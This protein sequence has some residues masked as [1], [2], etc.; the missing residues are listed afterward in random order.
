MDSK[1]DAFG[2]KTLSLILFL[3]AVAG[4]IAYY[5]QGVTPRSVFRPSGLAADYFSM[6]VG[7]EDV[8]RGLIST[9]VFFL[10]INLN[11][12]LVM[13]LVFLV[14]KNLIK[15]VLDRRRNILG[16]RLRSRLVS[17]FVGLSLIPT[18]LLFFVAKGILERV[19]GGWFSPQVEA[20]VEG[21]LGVARYHYDAAEAGVYRYTRHL[22]REI[23]ELY[24]YLGNAP[25]DSLAGDAQAMYSVIETYLSA[26]RQEYGLL[27]LA[28]LNEF[29]VTLAAASGIEQRHRLVEAP[30]ANLAAVN[31]A[32]SGVIL[33]RT[34][35]SINA[36]F[37]RGYAPVNASVFSG[38]VSGSAMQRDRSSPSSGAAASFTPA[39]YVI[40]ATYWVPPE[41]SKTLATVI[42]AHEDYIELKSYRR[43]L[44]SSYFLT[45]VV[46]TLLIVFGAIWVGF[47]LAKQLSIP[48]GLIAEGTQQVA[49]GN[50]DHRIPEVGDDELSVLVRDFNIMTKDLKELTEKLLAGRR[51]METVLARVGVG[52]ISINRDSFVTTCNISACE[53][54][55]LKKS[56][57]PASC[58]YA[59]IMPEALA[60][61]VGEELAQLYNAAERI[62]TFSLSCNV[63]SETKH[64]QVTLSKMVDDKGSPMGTVILLDDITELVS[65]QRM[66]AWREVARR[67]AHEIKNPLTPI[68]L[69]AERIQRRISAATS[70][71]AGVSQQTSAQAP[72]VLEV[73]ELA[74]LRDA[75]GI[76]VQQVE[77]LRLLVNEFS[78]FARMPKAQ[79]RP[80]H[81]NQVAAETF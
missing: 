77:N 25:D 51:Y 34:E 65:A 72:L 64:L 24:P 39:K 73:P 42:N 57:F 59:L 49:H 10:L 46:V 41:L 56:E 67:I 48:I 23:A 7:E 71:A 30:A 38:L 19:L 27:E 17:A 69:N 47:Y 36:D 4:L 63:G 1:R 37:L 53:I 18:V 8:E 21:A 52:V 43:P 44:V 54:L 26:K 16:A 28:L 31:E 33:V 11:I 50:L 58:Q 5:L 20:S 78:D 66:A 60:F 12:I 62:S 55:G 14:A 6:L 2:L 61:K 9:L 22:A 76:I 3:A 35:Q 13:V 79:L 68:Q 29:G 75:T 74:L 32:R 40:T 45:L 80:D 15:L 70:Q 81:L